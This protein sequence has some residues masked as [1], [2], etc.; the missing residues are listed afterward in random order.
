MRGTAK[1]SLDPGIR[2][3][4][5]A[6]EDALA[7]LLL[8]AEEARG[9]PKKFFE[10]V[11]RDEVFN[12]PIKVAPH[13]ELVLEFA[14]AHPNWVAMLPFGHAKTFSLA[15]LMLQDIGEDP[16]MRGALV[17]AAQAQAEKPL[18]LV[19]QYIESSNELKL[20]YPRL[21][22]SRRGG[23]PWT[24]TNI[25][26]AR[27]PGIRNPS[28]VARG[29]DSKQILG[30]RWKRVIVDNLMNGENTRTP[31]QREKVWKFLQ[32]DVRTRVN[33]VGGKMGY[34]C[35]AWH[36]DNATH[37][38]IRARDARG[39]GVA[40]ARH[41]GGRRDLHP[42]HQ[43]G[44]PLIVPADNRPAGNPLAEYRLAC[45][46]PGET[47]WPARWSREAL[48][49]RREELHPAIY[50]QLFL[51]ICRDNTTSLCRQEYVNRALKLGRDMGIHRLVPALPEG[52]PHLVFAG[53]DLAFS[54]S[55]AADEL[56]IFV[57]A[58]YPDPAQD[59]KLQIRVPLWIEAGR[60]GTDELYQRLVRINNAFRPAGIAVE[61][62]AAQE[63]VRQLMATANKSLVLKPHRTN[64][65][66][67][68]IVLGLPSIFA[69][70]ANG[71]WAIPNAPGGHVDP[72]LRKFIDQ[73][74]YYSP[75]EHS[76]DILMAAFFARD[77]AKKYGALTRKASAGAPGK[78]NRVAATLLAR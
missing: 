43:L 8:E 19:R 68:S 13:Q 20:V 21:E 11:L 50:N 49:E 29:Q 69:E 9:D 71:A 44:F 1:G 55:N 35:T 34:I 53:V 66:K 3:D 45:H 41:A 6:L 15:G 62:N 7:E 17:S 37:R 52:F 73:C 61:S 24:T 56:A 78:D 63:G 67:N 25:T 26:V 31:E 54:K 58:V 74:L 40:G 14:N 30:S 38:L 5:E 77:L 28:L 47:L 39:I 48:Q 22:R 23:E 46:P 70:M 75:A 16:L 36:P 60:W 64:A 10:F 33:P 27:P 51:N 2:D 42:Q 57:F 59:G 32:V 76:G 65:T 18:A 12:E 4:P 72:M